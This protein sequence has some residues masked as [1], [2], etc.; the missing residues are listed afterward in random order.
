VPLKK[1]KASLREFVREFVDGEFAGLGVGVGAADGDEQGEGER[2]RD[3]VWSEDTRICTDSACVCCFDS[4]VG[5]F[6]GRLVGGREFVDQICTASAC[7][8]CSDTL[9]S[10]IFEGD[11]FT[12]SIIGRCSIS[13]YS[14]AAVAGGCAERFSEATL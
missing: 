4:L 1:P 13:G 11:S 14:S 6:V 7:V 10:W 3:D 12:S 2:E 9:G 8:C 5:E